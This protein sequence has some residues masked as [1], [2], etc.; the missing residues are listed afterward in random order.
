MT[1]SVSSESRLLPDQTFVL[2]ALTQLT[3]R[4]GALEQ[5][6][7]TLREHTDQAAFDEGMLGSLPEDEEGTFS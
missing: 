1:G 2:A 4:V 7:E 3:R 6:L 5:Q